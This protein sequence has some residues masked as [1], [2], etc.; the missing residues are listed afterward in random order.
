M[1][2][3]VTYVPDDL[4]RLLGTEI[5]HFEYDTPAK[6]RSVAVYTDGRREEFDSTVT[7]QRLADHRRE[8]D[9]K[10]ERMPGSQLLYRYNLRIENPTPHKQLVRI[11]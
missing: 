3:Y 7:E 8:E 1:R 5:D 6:N 9:A 4:W 10:W 2:P 11:V